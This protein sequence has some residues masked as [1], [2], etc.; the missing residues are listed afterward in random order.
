MTVGTKTKRKVTNRGMARILSYISVIVLLLLFVASPV[1]AISNPDTI[2]F[3]TGSIPLY[4]VFTN[5]SET[6][7]ML[8]VAEGY[9]HYITTPTDYTAKQAFLF[10]VLDPTGTT[11][12]V[13]TTLQEYEDRPISIYQ[14]KAQV[15]ALPLVPG[16]AYGLRIRGNPTIFP[17]PTG[18]TVTAY[19]A[20][21]D[22]VTQTGA[23]DTN[24][25]LRDFLIIMATN[26][27]V[28][29][30]A[31][32]IITAATPYIV[33][34][35]GVRYLTILGG[36]IFLAGIPALSSMCAI[37]FQAALEPMQGDVPASTGAYAQALTPLTQWGGTIASGLTTLGS[38]LGISQSLAGSVM[39]LILVTA[40]AVFIYK[41]T[42]SGIAVLL[43]VAATPFMGA[44]LGLMP[45][46]L[47]FIFVIFIIVLLG[48]FFFSRGAL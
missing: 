18:N 41:Q 14:T 40:F 44:F 39:L 22:Y 19:L 1:F 13:S 31:V 10:E 7:D 46:A 2:T 34:V 43:M 16:T 35:Q 6:G 25:P 27:Q 4:K 8:F 37:L 20:A 33:N 38:Y 30:I 11:V 15:D 42:E 26:I 23:T 9:V 36:N 3:G 21:S 12:L 5:V 47:A 24:N 17:S 32:G 45:M 28:H 48:Y 29:D